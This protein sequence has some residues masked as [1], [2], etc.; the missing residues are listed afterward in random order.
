MPYATSDTMKRNCLVTIV[1]DAK[2]M[3][4]AVKAAARSREP[5]V[6]IA[7]GE[8][9]QSNML[10]RRLPRN[11]MLADS[12]TK[13]LSKAHL[14]HLLDFM[15]SGWWQLH[16]EQSELE[17]RQEEKERAGRASHFKLRSGDLSGSNIDDLQTSA[18]W[19]TKSAG[20]SL[21]GLRSIAFAE[22]KFGGTV[23]FRKTLSFNADSWNASQPA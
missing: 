21:Y 8:I 4:D 15:K 18:Q 12:V 19:R 11:R 7:I 20:V 5:R 9:Q 23:R 3:Y 10:C 14:K 16:S 17:Q 6:G 13:R 2:S 1:T 22:L